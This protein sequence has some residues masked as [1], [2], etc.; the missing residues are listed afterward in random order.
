MNCP[1]CIVVVGTRPEA[2]KMAPVVRHLRQHCAE[3][4]TKLLLTAQHREMLD[5]VLQIFAMRAD[6]D[7]NLMQEAQRLPSFAADAVK[8][9]SRV[10]VQ[11]KPD[12]VLVQGDTTTAFAASLA[13][14][15]ERI[16]VVHVEAGLRSNDMD[17]PFPEEMNRRLITILARM[18]FAPTVHARENLI[19]ECVDPLRI[20]VTG[21][22]VIDAL[23]LI[24]NDAIGIASHRF[25]F[26]ENGLRTVLVT[27]HRRENH[28]EPIRRICHAISLLVDR[29][30]DIQ[31]V[32]P[33]H[34]HPLVE[35]TVRKCLHEKERIYLTE[36]LDYCSFVGVLA[37]SEFALSDSGGIQ[38]EG[39]ALGKPVLILRDTTE[40]PEGVFA[41]VTR[42]VGTTEDRILHEA[43]RL[44]ESKAAYS[45]MARRVSPYGDGKAAERI[46]SA[47]CSHFGIEPEKNTFA[48]SR[49][50][51]AH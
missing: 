46:V 19:R 48:P 33:V 6:I 4:K 15:Y 37:L 8:H 2:I 41:G 26:I 28:G 47:I 29:Y 14:F 24:R 34:P 17:R 7:L 30:P 18:H 39:P 38:E 45:E 21:N 12:L 9:V 36:P 13:A 49:E 23:H 43:S 50:Q 31:V 11:E 25:P 10:F 3:I 27:A 32:W 40:R 22:P 20:F 51:Y 16:A 35:N 44:L 5:Q 1:C 42:L